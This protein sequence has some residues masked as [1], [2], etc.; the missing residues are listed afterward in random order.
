MVACGYLGVLLPTTLQ[1]LGVAV[2]TCKKPHTTPVVLKSVL[3]HRYMLHD[4]GRF[5]SLQ[6]TLIHDCVYHPQPHRQRPF[7]RYNMYRSDRGFRPGQCV[8]TS[9][10]CGRLGQNLSVVCV[11]QWTGTSTE[12]VLSCAVLPVLL[13]CIS[14][15][16]LAGSRMRL[17]KTW[18]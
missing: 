10:S 4:T 15:A 2:L 14:R 1:V 13:G 5:R 6:C 17:K 12:S 8:I 16:V 7:V 9:L 3:Q 18:V 11:L